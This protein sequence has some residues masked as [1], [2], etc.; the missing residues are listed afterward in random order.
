MTT[1]H[2]L[3]LGLTSLSLLL[4]A[5]GDDGDA[6]TT[7]GPG[8][9]G[10]GGNDTGVGGGGTGG[11]G[12]SGYTLTKIDGTFATPESCYWNAQQQVWYV[13]NVAPMSEDLTQP[14]GVGWISRIGSDGVVMDEQWV[15]GLDTPAGMRMLNGTLWVSNI[16]EV[17]GIDTETGAVVDTA[18]IPGATLLNDPAEDGESIYVTD[19]FGNAIY[20][21]TPPDLSTGVTVTSM[22]LQGPNGLLFDGGRLY[23]ASLADFDP[24]T[25]GPFLTFDLNTKDI[26]PFGALTGKLDGLEKDGEDFLVSDFSTARIF[27]VKPDGSFETAYDLKAE[28]LV[29]IADHG[30]DPASGTLCIPDLQGNAVFLLRRD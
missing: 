29:T 1:K 28:G 9:I 21:F 17:V 15:T 6:S 26:A 7:T 3:L 16:N 27:R 19:T 30:I 2:L 25:M 5:C 20:S 24:A 10:A 13:S 18:S 22:Q 11:G 8:G 4:A 14:D 23:I 12:G